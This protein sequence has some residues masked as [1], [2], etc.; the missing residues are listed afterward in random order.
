MHASPGTI[1]P[2]P[3]TDQY[4]MLSRDQNLNLLQNVQDRQLIEED[5]LMARVGHFSNEQT[6]LIPDF[7]AADHYPLEINVSGLSDSITDVD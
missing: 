1:C 5:G 4:N 7:G 3:A 6:I 2:R